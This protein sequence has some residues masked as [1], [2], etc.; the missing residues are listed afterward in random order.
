MG[1][2]VLSRIEVDDR[3]TPRTIALY[4]GDLAA[5]P[6]EHALDLLIISA[7][8][9]DY[10]PTPRSVIGALAR[11]GLS[12]GGLARNKAHDLRAQ[13][14]FWL[15]QPIET[16][17]MH[18]NRLACFESR[19]N[20]RPSALVGD[21]FRGLFPFLDPNGEQVV[22]MPLL[23]TG[24]QGWPKRDMME[25]LL[26]AATH[27]LSRG[28]PIRELKIVVPPSSASNAALV[29]VFESFRPAIEP[30][31]APIADVF[32]S[33]SSTDVE[34]AT[35]TEEAL[36]TRPDISDVFNFRTDIQVGSSWQREIDKAIQGARALVA[37]VSPDYLA[38]PEC[39]EELMVARLRHKH[40][41]P[42]L[43]PIWWRGAD[44]SIDLWLRT[45]NIADCR[46]QDAARL[47]QSLAGLSFRAG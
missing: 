14:A 23:A 7:F 43:Y 15:S 19:M 42:F 33:Y 10:M 35:R 18:I 31:V 12:V 38:S 1:F 46:E 28:L 17:Q 11:A 32:L 22:G 39:Q 25:A 9:N 37:L 30:Q 4:A 34:I 20:G 6:A 40:D 41:G 3:S 13:C 16:P 36:L 26:D 45:V 21:L 24:D 44:D 27:W 5:I 29:D 8:P 47:T 2:E